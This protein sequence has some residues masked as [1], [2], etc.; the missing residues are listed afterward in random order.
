MTQLTIIFFSCLIV[1]LVFDYFWIKGYHT[2]KPIPKIIATVIVM[3]ITGIWLALHLEKLWQ[4]VVI[5]IAISAVWSLLF[6]PIRN[7]ISGKPFNYMSET[8]WPDKWI[9]KY[10]NTYWLYTFFRVIVIV[11]LWG[12]IRN[13][14]FKK[15]KQS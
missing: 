3:A 10:F 12:M 9:L 6:D 5:S 13:V 11:F 4:W 2:M 14:E 15:Y 7:L 1:R 8:T